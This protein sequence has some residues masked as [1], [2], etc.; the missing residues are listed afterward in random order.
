MGVIKG[1][2]M[3]R[4]GMLMLAVV[5]VGTVIVDKSP[6]GPQLYPY[7]MIIGITSGG[8]FSVIFFWLKLID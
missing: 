6:I 7:P 4:F 1:V 8:V 3:R 5:A 2:V